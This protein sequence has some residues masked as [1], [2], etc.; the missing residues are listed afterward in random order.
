[1]SNVSVITGG[2]HSPDRHINDF[3]PTPTASTISLFQANVLE[4]PTIKTVLEPACGLNHIV[5][6]VR[7]YLPQV[8]ITAFDLHE[9]GDESI[10]T[11][12]DYLKIDLHQ[13]DLVITNPPYNKKLLM[14]F[15]EK[16][17]KDSSRYTAMFL[18]VTF[19]ESISRFKFFEENKTLRHVLVF[20]NRQPM[21]RAGEKMK[22]SNAIMYAWFVWDKQFSGDPTIKWLENSKL[23]KELEI[24]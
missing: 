14:P 12:I 19:L 13:S 9:Y 6:V 23:I 21:R 17:L 5:N 16:A 1:M 20:S 24:Y 8:E 11:G 7:D 2:V 18:K 22:N 15:V 4:L 10:T 3:Y